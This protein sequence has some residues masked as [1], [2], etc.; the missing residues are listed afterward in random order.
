[1]NRYHRVTLLAVAVLALGACGSDSDDKYRVS[2]N[3]IGED[4][5]LTVDEGTLHCHSHAIVF[6]DPDGNEWAVNGQ[7]ISAGYAEIDP[8][9]ADNPDIDGA[10]LNLSAL[11][12]FGL[13]IC[14]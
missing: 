7:A 2:R 13:T 5:P 10:K 3:L 12:P 4:W 1:M 14:D 9:W 8:I 6:T 11:N